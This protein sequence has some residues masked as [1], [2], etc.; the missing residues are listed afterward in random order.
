MDLNLAFDTATAAIAKEEGLKTTAYWDENGYAIGYGNHRYMDGS[1]VQNGDTI[2]PDD[3][4][5]LLKFYVGQFYNEQ[6]Q[7]KITVDQN[8]NQIAALI[9]VSYNCGSIPHNLRDTINS[10]A[11]ADQIDAAFQSA[12]VTSGGV[13]NSDLY[14][15]RVRENTLY[16][17]FV[18]GVHD[19]AVNHPGWTVIGG[20]ALLGGIFYGIVRLAKI[21]K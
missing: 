5:A 19:F 3:A 17:S 2:A 6:V 7:P 20:V 1:Y 15:R 12:C 13:Y 9:S 18:Q 16:D 8:E 21:K 11:P 4:L 10:G 14:K